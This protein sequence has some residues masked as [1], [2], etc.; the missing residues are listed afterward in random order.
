MPRPFGERGARKA[1][2]GQ[3]VQ[4]GLLEH[5]AEETLHAVCPESRV[6]KELL[7]VE[8]EHAQAGMLAQ[9]CI[10][11]GDFILQLQVGHQTLVAPSHG[12][13]QLVHMVAFAVGDRLCPPVASGHLL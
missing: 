7:P 10:V 12:H 4:F 6:E 9:V 1:D 3:V 13:L 2:V 8:V 11:A 5:L